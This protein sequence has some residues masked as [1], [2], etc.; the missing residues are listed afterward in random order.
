[1][2]WILCSLFSFPLLPLLFPLYFPLYPY[3]TYLAPSSCDRNRPPS[4]QVAC[5]LTLF[6]PPFT[7]LS[8]P[9][10]FPRTP[11]V[12]RLT[13]TTLGPLRSDYAEQY[14]L[15]SSLCV[16]TLPLLL[17]VSLSL[18]L[19]AVSLLCLFSALHLTLRLFTLKSLSSVLCL[20]QYV[21]PL[22]FVPLSL[23]LYIFVSVLLSTPFLSLSI[24]LF[25]ISPL[26][27]FLSPSVSGVSSLSLCLS[28]FC[29]SPSLSSRCLPTLSL[30]VSLLLSSV[31]LAASTPFVSPSP[32]LPCL[33]LS[34][35]P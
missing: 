29:L 26:S 27:L 8:H 21:S 5:E 25:P 31:S 6:A 32:C 35:C 30:Y 2:A 18:C 20:A 13:T 23:P 34:A 7:Q 28:P 11:T 33:F 19:P 10:Q 15:F 17:S 22:L 3:S 14:G 1:M 16:P 12:Q 9:F 4:T 24:Y